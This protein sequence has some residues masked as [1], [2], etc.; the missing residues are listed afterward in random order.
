MGRWGSVSVLTEEE[1]PE[2]GEALH[3]AGAGA[4]RP[5]QRAVHPQGLE[6]HRVGKCDTIENGYSNLVENR[7]S[8]TWLRSDSL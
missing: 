7:G 3:P 2:L 6:C 4:L 8:R 5:L 1:G